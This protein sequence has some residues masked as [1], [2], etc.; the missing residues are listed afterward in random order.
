[1]Y[2]S[3][4]LL[5]MYNLFVKSHWADDQLQMLLQQFEGSLQQQGKPTVEKL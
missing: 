5:Q 3:S 2:L 1:M 4:I